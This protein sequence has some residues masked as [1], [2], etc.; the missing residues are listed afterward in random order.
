MSNFSKAFSST[1]GRKLI[2]SLTGLFLCS[3]LIIHLI[4]NFQLFKDDAG[5]AFNQYAHFMTNFTPIKVVSYLLYTSIIVHTVWAIILTRKNNAARPQGYAIKPKDGSI[6]SSRNMGI[7]GTIIFVFIVVHMS[8][9]W[10]KYHQGYTPFIEYSTDLTTGATTSRELSASEFT[11]Y[12]SYVDNGVEIT[13]SED[14]Y[15]EVSTAFKQWWL[16]AF[17]IIAMVALAFH[18]IHGFQSAFQ[19]LG[20]DHSKYKNLINFLGVWVFGVL[21]PLGFASMPLYFLFK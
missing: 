18:L 1:L 20:W 21:I 9:F 14:L 10:F 4:G 15:L 2:M 19:T 11:K 13:K 5:L 17:Y 3:F 8:N 6:W 7:L 16:V 12:V